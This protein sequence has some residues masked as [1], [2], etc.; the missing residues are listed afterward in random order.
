MTKREM[1]QYETLVRV[2]DFGTTNADRFPEPSPARQGFA[3]VDR[4]V[5]ELTEYAVAQMAATRRTAKVRAAA[6][7]ALLDALETVSRTARVIAASER[8]FKNTFQLPRRR[9][10]ALLTTGRLFARDAVPAAALFA[11]H[12]MPE[13]F[14][15]DLNGLVERFEQ[16]IRARDEGK[17]ESAAAR[18]RIEAALAAGMGA[19]RQ[20][21]SS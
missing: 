4:T 5:S 6:R 2:R 17:G 1:R 20:W 11:A 14:L 7:E 9:P 12:G 21:T 15:S 13:T 18:A 19:A 3:T 10:Q 16:A 8:A